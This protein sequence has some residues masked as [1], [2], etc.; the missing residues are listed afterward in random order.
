MRSAVELELAVQARLAD[1]ER[2]FEARRWSRELQGAESRQ[3]A[4]SRGERQRMGW[5]SAQSWLGWVPLPGRF[6]SP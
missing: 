3:Q 6:G 5:W 1:H 2:Q 4:G